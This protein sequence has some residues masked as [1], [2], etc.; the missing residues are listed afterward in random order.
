M[1]HSCPGPGRPVSNQNPFLLLHVC[2]GPCAAHVIDLLK[3]DHRPLCFFFN[4]N[5]HPEEEFLKRLRAA[6]HVCRTRQVA[7]WIPSYQPAVWLKRVSGLEDEPEGGERCTICFRFRMEV[8]ALAARLAS[9]PAFAT[10]LSVSPHK[11]SLLINEIGSQVSKKHG[12]EFLSADFKKEN[13]HKKS[14]EKSKKLRLY[15]QRTCG[16]T[17]SAR[18]NG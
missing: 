18:K 9:I 10:T 2:C 7:L 3:S 4:P 12:I 17:F 14:V 11:Q 8:T 13:G 15:R 5:V 16:C 1:E 6:S